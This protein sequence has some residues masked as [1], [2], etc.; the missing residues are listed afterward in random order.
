MRDV[1]LPPQDCAGRAFVPLP[2]VDVAEP[3]AAVPVGGSVCA[4]V[5]EVALGVV[6]GEHGRNFKECLRVIKPRLYDG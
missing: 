5:A 1:S 3:R 4:R 6:I 2:V